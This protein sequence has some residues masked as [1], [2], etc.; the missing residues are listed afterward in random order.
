MAVVAWT[1]ALAISTNSFHRHQSSSAAWAGEDDIAQ[2]LVFFSDD[3]VAEAP[4]AL[5]YILKP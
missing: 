2:D 1:T 5:A 3:T 4:A